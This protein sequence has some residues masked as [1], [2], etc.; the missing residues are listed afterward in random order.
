MKD[1]IRLSKK[2]IYDVRGSLQDIVGGSNEETNTE[3]VSVQTGNFS[4]DIE[5]LNNDQSIITNLIALTKS[6]EKNAGIASK[7]TPE[8]AA[9]MQR[10]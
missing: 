3:R 2:I 5:K 10:Q 9:L 4:Q 8:Q 6:S 7:P 1:V